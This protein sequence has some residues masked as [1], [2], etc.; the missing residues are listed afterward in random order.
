MCRKSW[1]PTVKL[2]QVSDTIIEVLIWSVCEMGLTIVAGCGATLRTLF[3][4]PKKRAQSSDGTRGR[5]GRPRQPGDTVENWDP[6]LTICMV[7]TVDEESGNWTALASPI[8]KAA[9]V[10]IETIEE[11]RSDSRAH[12]QQPRTDGLI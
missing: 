9:E 11:E 12:L 4:T 7:G 10:Q 3:V 6:G 1:L 5:P 2:T 8:K